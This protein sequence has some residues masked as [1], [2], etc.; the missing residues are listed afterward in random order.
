MAKRY[1]VTGCAGFIASKV[2]ELLLRRGHCVVGIDN[3]DDAYDVRLKQWRLDQ[4]HHLDGFQFLQLDITNRE[5][6]SNAFDQQA[7]ST[8][9]SP[10]FDAVLH[11]AARAGVRD[12][13]DRPEIYYRANCD[14]T[15]NVLEACRKAKIPKF[16]FASTSSL[17]GDQREV[18]FHEGLNTDR[19]LSP[20]AASKKAAETLAYAYHHLYGLDISIVR[21]FT[22]Y[23]PAGRP[24]MCIFRFIRHIAQGEPLVLFGDGTQQR[25]FTFLDDA[26]A[27]TIAALKPTGYEIFNLA[28]GRSI[29]LASVIDQIARQLGQ[30]PHI[31]QRSPHSA[32]V[33]TTWGDISKAKRLLN[34]QPQTPFDEG[35]R[36]AV[37][38]FRNNNQLAVSVD[39]NEK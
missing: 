8:A 18:P 12:S 27:G 3:L 13:V 17:Y 23:G 20:Y 32:D 34:W 16:V 1:L 14:G 38:W 9:K 6:L 11:L 26:A 30:K 22:V 24:D 19:P 33:A 15:L 31:E 21:Y 5:S 4:L 37:D 7:S 28:A 10:A 39:L 2:T 29:P 35:L 36:Q 25:D